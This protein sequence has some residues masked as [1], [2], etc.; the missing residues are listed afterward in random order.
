MKLVRV[1]AVLVPLPAPSGTAIATAEAPAGD[2][3]MLERGAKVPP[4]RS[5]DRPPCPAG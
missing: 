3:S 5:R 1:S 2:F 4:M